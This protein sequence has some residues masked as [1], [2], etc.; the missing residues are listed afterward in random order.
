MRGDVAALLDAGVA[1]V[2]AM[3][4]QRRRLHSRQDITDVG[5]RVHQH[6]VTRRPGTCSRTRARHPPPRE[7]RVG[8]RRHTTEVG[9]DAPFAFDRGRVASPFLRRLAPRVVV[10]GPCPLRVGSVQGKRPYALRIGCGEQN[11]ERSTFRIAEQRRALTADGVHHGTHVIHSRLKV[12][13]PNRAI[14]KTGPTLVEPN[15]PRKGPKSLEQSPRGGMLPV[16]VEMRHESRNEHKVERRLAGHLVRDVDA[17]A[18][19]IANRRL[20]AQDSRAL[21]PD[22]LQPGGGACAQS[23]GRAFAKVPRARGP[24]C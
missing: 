15:Q 24:G 8:A 6:K 19:R 9:F 12:R 23:P 14:G 10:I 21:R 16:V 1:V 3:D 13:Q 11:R 18:P 20:H 7:R 5:L 22:S 17:T 4:N 2:G